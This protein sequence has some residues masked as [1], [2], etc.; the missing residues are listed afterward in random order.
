MFLYCTTLAPC[1]FVDEEGVPKSVEILVTY[2]VKSVVLIFVQLMN[3]T[4]HNFNLFHLEGNTNNCIIQ[5]NV[6]NFCLSH[7]TSNYTVYLT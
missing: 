7:D 5:R 4:I 3:L 6:R 2:D 1:T